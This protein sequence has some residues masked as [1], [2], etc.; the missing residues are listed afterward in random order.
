MDD[1]RDRNDEREGATRA[2]HVLP[3]AIFWGT[4]I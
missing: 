3:S 2:P 4:P 1:E